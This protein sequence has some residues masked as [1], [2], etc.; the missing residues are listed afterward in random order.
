M[1]VTGA[2]NKIIIDS[3]PVYIDILD[4]VREMGENFTSGT[5]HKQLVTVSMYQVPLHTQTPFQDYG[6]TEPEIHTSKSQNDALHARHLIQ[7]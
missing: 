5:D 6:D 3:D 2:S 1:N 4:A 7:K